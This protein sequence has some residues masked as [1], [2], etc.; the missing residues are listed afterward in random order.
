MSS[1]LHS[2]VSMYVRIYTHVRVYMC[3]Y[4]N[5]T[6]L[7]AAGWGAAHASHGHDGVVTRRFQ[8]F[9]LFRVLG[10]TRRY[11]AAPAS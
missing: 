7:T 8:G 9:H 1:R 4:A 2:S 5:I 3:V 6:R 11:C 10:V